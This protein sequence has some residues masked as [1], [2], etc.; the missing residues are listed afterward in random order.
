MIIEWLTSSLLAT[1]FLDSV[2][3]G[4]SSVME[5]LISLTLISE[6]YFENMEFT[7]E[8]PRITP[9]KMAK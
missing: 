6:L 8:L 4:R 2:V 9:K 7:I 5:D 1:Y 3:L